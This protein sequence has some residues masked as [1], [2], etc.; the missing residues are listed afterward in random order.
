MDSFET[1]QMTALRLSADDFELLNYFYTNEEVCRTLGGVKTA[2]WV[3]DYITKNNAHWEKFGFGN[4][5]FYSKL[6]GEFAGKGAIRHIEL[7]NIDEIEIGYA[8][9]PKY[10]GKGYASEIAQKLVYLAF[11]H[12]KLTDIIAITLPHNIAS[13][14]VMEK[15][16]LI[17]EKEVVYTNLLHVLYRLKKL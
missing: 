13:R 5:N 7:E 8:F 9:L 4:W 14:R 16:G 3:R 17:Y 1:K 10:W 6:D 15:A 2:D 12:I 11:Y